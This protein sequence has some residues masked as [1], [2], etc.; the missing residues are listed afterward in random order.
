MPSFEEKMAQAA[1]KKLVS[2]SGTLHSIHFK[3][4]NLPD[5][6]IDIM[7]KL[8]L[9]EQHSLIHRAHRFLVIQVDTTA[10]Q[11]QLSELEILR[12]EKELEDKYLFMGA[13]LALMQRLFGTHAADFSRRRSALS[14]RGVGTGRP[15]ACDEA[16][17]LRIWKLW[18]THQDIEERLRFIK[19]AEEA[20]IDLH[21]IWGALKPYLDK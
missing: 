20:G 17:E 12:D 1:A 21:M 7:A 11:R 8:N 14:I 15:P 10:L 5:E 19:V 2:S 13:P 3:T 18:D 4:S 6:I 16:T 9:A